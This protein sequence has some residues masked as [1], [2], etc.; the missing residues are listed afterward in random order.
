MIRRGIGSLAFTV[1]LEN[2][3]FLMRSCGENHWFLQ[4]ILRKQNQIADCLAKK[5][6][7]EKGDLQVIDVPPEMARVVIYKT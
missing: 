4:Y 3:Q 7:L 1:S 2:V 5:A 6:L